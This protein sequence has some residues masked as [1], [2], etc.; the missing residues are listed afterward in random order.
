MSLN[1]VHYVIESAEFSHDCKLAGNHAIEIRHLILLRVG[2]RYLL[3]KLLE[4]V[5]LDG[6]NRRRIS[7]ILIQVNSG[8]TA[9][10]DEAHILVVSDELSTCLEA[11][12]YLLKAC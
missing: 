3:R 5:G 6:D 9:P 11:G 4:V 7:S 12:A 2:I 10:R 1:C 8:L